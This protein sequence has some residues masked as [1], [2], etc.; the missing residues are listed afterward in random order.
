MPLSSVAFLQFTGPTIG[1]LIALAVGERLSVTGVASFACIWASVA[2]FLTGAWRRSR[3]LEG[4]AA[5]P[6][7]QPS[8]A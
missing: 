4:V 7:A 8:E 6:A 3:R 5:A 1:F 2:V